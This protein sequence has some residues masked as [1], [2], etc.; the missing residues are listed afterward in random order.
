M[1]LY[2]GKKTFV[3]VGWT[4]LKEKTSYY[5]VESGAIPSY[6]EKVIK[7]KSLMNSGRC[8][9]VNEAVEKVNISRSTYYKY[10]DKV[11]PFTESSKGKIITFGFT[12][13]D[14]PGVLSQMLGTI[15]KAKANILTINQS[16]PVNTIANIT[17]SIKT[18]E[19]TH[20]I[21]ELIKKLTAIEGVNKADILSGE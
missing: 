5:L 6:F 18:T 8:K 4:F 15:A 12:V 2:F 11:Y 1:L 9:T 17:I 7:V 13:Q 20:D 14:I 10:K 16:I 21:M 19:S 3:L